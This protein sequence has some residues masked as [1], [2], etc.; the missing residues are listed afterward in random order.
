MTWTHAAA[1][2][3]AGRK[4][5]RIAPGATVNGS[6]MLQKWTGHGH[7]TTTVVYAHAVGRKEQDI[8]ASGTKLN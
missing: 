1:N 6:N 4:K 2:A 7:L 8:T 5:S 3:T